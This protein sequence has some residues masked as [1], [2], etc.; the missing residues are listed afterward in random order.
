MDAVYI[1]FGSK[2]F[3]CKFETEILLIKIKDQ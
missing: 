2:L 3:L 1:S